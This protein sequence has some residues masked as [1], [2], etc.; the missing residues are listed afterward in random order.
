MRTR[1]LAL[2][3]AVICGFILLQLRHCW[4]SRSTIRGNRKGTGG[5][6]RA[7]R[8]P[9]EHQGHPVEDANPRTWQL[10]HAS[11]R[12]GKCGSNRPRPTGARRLLLCLSTRTGP[13]KS[14]GRRKW[15]SGEAEDAE[16][17]LVRPHAR[18]RQTVYALFWDHRNGHHLD[19]KGEQV[20]SSSWGGWRADAAPSSPCAR[21]GIHQFRPRT[22]TRQSDRPRCQDRQVCL[23]FSVTFRACSPVHASA[24]PMAARN[25]SS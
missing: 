6:Q 2:P 5:E 11:Y 16:T 20:G 8:V 24:G 7:C 23:D 21:R 18:R 13:G 4:A 15:P 25:S 1:S 19:M 22:D 9:V 10:G 12:T 14:S 3:I 17:P